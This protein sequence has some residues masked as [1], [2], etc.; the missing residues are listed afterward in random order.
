MLKGDSIFKLREKQLCF[1]FF[2][3][4]VIHRSALWVIT[5]LDIHYSN[6][7]SLR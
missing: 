2:R 4:L 5:H 1:V 6:G 3:I 7:Y